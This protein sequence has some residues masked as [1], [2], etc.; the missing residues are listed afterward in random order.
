MTHQNSFKWS[1]LPQL[2]LGTEG[3][4]RLIVGDSLPM[5]DDVALEGLNAQ[6]SLSC[7][8]NTSWSPLTL[9]SPRDPNL[10]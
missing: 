9:S 5:T 2:S 1:S 7:I 8:L 3:Q 10:P 4:K 6:V